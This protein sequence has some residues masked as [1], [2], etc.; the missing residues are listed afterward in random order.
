MA[1]LDRL[2]GCQ[3][4]VWAS[5]R[6]FRV[7]TILTFYAVFTVGRTLGCKFR[8]PWKQL[9]Q[10]S[11]PREQSSGKVSWN[12]SLHLGPALAEGMLVLM[13]SRGVGWHVVGWGERCLQERRRLGEDQGSGLPTEPVVLVYPGRSP[14]ECL[15]SIRDGS[16]FQISFSMFFWLLVLGSERLV[17]FSAPE[18]F[19]ALHPGWRWPLEVNSES[20]VVI[21]MPEAASVLG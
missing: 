10:E 15:G 5:Q 14:K 8:V 12:L 1:A 20:L 7:S 16:P 2:D 9:C 21:L 4:L 11:N 13:T 3:P 17:S 6:I 18:V 19:L